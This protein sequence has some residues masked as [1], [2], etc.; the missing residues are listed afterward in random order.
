MRVSR[1]QAEA[2][3]ERVIDV[4]SRLF[5]RHGFD[6]IG[7]KDLMEAAGLTQGG[8]Y[9]QF[10]SKED[11]AANACARGYAA[12]RERW[13]EFAAR[14]PERPLVPLVRAYLSP[15][16]RDEQ[17]EGC[18][19]AALGPDAARAGPAVRASMEEGVVAYVDFLEACLPD[20]LD[21]RRRRAMAIASTMIGAMVLSRSVND[22]VLSKEILDASI[23]DILDRPAAATGRENRGSTSEH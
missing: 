16:H 3:R 22:P 10:A 6:G 17:A 8:F 21:D 1:A 14:D 11:L 20:D 7:L 19:M 13:R 15:E 2:N 23:R 4:A 9:K 18:V 12:V 5:R